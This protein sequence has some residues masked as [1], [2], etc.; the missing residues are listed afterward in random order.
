MRWDN[1]GE[2]ITEDGRKVFFRGKEDKHEHGIRFPVHKGIMNTVMGSCPVSS[3]LIIIC[4]RAVPFNTT[5]VRAN[6]PTSDY[7]NDKMGEFYDKPQNVIDKTL[8]KD[9][10]VMPGDWNAKWGKDAYENW[11]GNC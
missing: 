11:Q 10:L 1:F 9:I 3:R 8:K 4:Q 6:A 7:D 2:T 5:I